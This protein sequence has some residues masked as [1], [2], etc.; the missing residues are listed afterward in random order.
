MK[1]TAEQ[2]PEKA[3]DCCCNCRFSSAP[4]YHIYPDQSVAEEPRLRC[5]RRSPVVA[6][7]QVSAAWTAWPLVR[8]TEWCGEFERDD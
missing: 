6:G 1:I 7:G 2:A 8:P 3:V 4:F 5:H